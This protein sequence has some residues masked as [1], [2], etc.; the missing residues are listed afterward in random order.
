VGAGDQH[1]LQYT[2]TGSTFRL[3]TSS[4]EDTLA[5]NGECMYSMTLYYSDD[6]QCRAGN[7]IEIIS[8]L[9]VAAV[10]CL[11]TAVFCAYDRLVRRRNAK[12]V[13][14]AARSNAIIS[15]LFPKQVRD[16]LFAENEAH[17]PSQGK[18]KLKMESER[19][20]GH[21]DDVDESV[22]KTKPIAD[23]FP[24][25]TVLFA[26]IAGFTSWSSV[27]EPCQVSLVQ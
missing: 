2:H 17:E 7:H 8:A 16:R 3:K 22:F 18:T 26:D 5:V 14:A 13:D 15:S 11:M 4:D 25:T 12:I 20:L 24:E 23:L 1:D 9:A 27:R 10:F 19:L 6:F 21:N